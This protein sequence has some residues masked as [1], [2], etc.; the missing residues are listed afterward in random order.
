M[1]QTASTRFVRV[2]ELQIDP[3]QLDAFAGSDPKARVVWVAGE[4]AA[5]SLATTRLTETWIHTVDV[6]V[7]FGGPPPPT[8]RLWHTAWSGIA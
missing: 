4:L 5:R 2:A 6:A 3:A 1:A 8:D 7:A